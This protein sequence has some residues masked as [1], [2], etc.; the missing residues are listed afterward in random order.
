MSSSSGSVTHWLGLLRAGDAVAAQPLWEG[1]F[2]RLVGLARARL[3]GV[4]RRAAD[5]EDVARSAFD[6]FCQGAQAGR[7]PR[8]ADRDDLWQ[9]LVLLT[10]RKAS[11][12]RRHEQR[13]KR[14]GGR[15][16]TETDLAASEPETDAILAEVVGSEPTPEFAAQVAEECQ[17]LLDL[18]KEDDLR[19]IALA[20]MEGYGTEEIAARLDCAPRTVQRKLGRIRSLW[21][22]EV[23]S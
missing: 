5:E 4:S 18:L 9:V 14:G 13:Q 20:K 17:R 15:V 11:R 8:L 19:A 22:R 10:A 2:R 3:Q 12:L 16:Q 7:F 6:S 23:L 1:Y 21:S